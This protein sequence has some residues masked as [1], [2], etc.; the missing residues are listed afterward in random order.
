MC[1]YSINGEK[2]ADHDIECWKVLLKHRAR[3]YTPFMIVRVPFLARI[4][5]RCFRAKRSYKQPFML[6]CRSYRVGIPYKGCWVVESGY[7]HLFSSKENA[8]DSYSI[9]VKHPEYKRGKPMETVI[10]R[11]IIP[12]GTKYYEG[13]EGD[14]AA[15][16][17]RI[18]ETMRKES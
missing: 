16:K 17:V 10:V 3:F 18:V 2:T 5:L 7:I 4:G 14:L 9:L 1:L 8:D 6:P 15:K 12:A 11:C 13:M